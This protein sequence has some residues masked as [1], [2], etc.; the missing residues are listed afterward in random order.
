ME[1][2]EL[3]SKTALSSSIFG[4]GVVPFPLVLKSCLDGGCFVLCCQQIGIW[5]KANAV[6]QS[7]YLRPSPVMT[8]AANTIRAAIT[9]ILIVQCVF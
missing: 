1:A 3:V 5:G 4:D 7:P 6:L 8:V 9:E 2:A